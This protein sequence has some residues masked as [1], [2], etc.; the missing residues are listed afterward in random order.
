MIRMMR[1]EQVD[2]VRQKQNLGHMKN[3]SP[4]HNPPHTTPLAYRQ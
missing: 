3:K 1:V 2:Y 4:R